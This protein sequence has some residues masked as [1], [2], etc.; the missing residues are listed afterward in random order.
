[1]KTYAA[2]GQFRSGARECALFD[3]PPEPKLLVI[4]PPEDGRQ[5]DREGIPIPGGSA[6]RLGGI[7]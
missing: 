6:T 5:D 4:L 3:T 1:M 2:A 7:L